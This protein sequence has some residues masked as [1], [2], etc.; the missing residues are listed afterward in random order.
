MERLVLSPIFW[1]SALF[2][3][4]QGMLFFYIL[5]RGEFK[6][7]FF[8]KKILNTKKKTIVLSLR[9]FR[10]QFKTGIGGKKKFVNK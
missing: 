7:R 2:F 8:K 5:G 9:H 3:S 4:R 10:T 1:N 6:I